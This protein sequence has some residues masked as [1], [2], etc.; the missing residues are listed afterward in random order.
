MLKKWEMETTT[1]FYFIS[2]FVIALPGREGGWVEELKR[3][4]HEPIFLFYPFFFFLFPHVGPI[5][6]NI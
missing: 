2:L 3:Q 5:L 6:H 4:M 1:V